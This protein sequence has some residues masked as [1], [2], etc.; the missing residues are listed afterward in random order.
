MMGNESNIFDDALD[1]LGAED[2]NRSRSDVAYELARSKFAEIE[3][4]YSELRGVVAGK[5]NVGKAKAF[6]LKNKG[7]LMAVAAAFGVPVG[8][9]DSGAFS[10]I[11]GMLGKITGLFGG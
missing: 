8:L 9:A 4:K 10:T 6:L 7:T 2:A 1:A 11:T 3:A 5:F